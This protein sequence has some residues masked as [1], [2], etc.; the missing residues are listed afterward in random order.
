MKGE[1]CPFRRELGPFRRL[2]LKRK[3]EYVPIERYRT[4]HVAYEYDRLAYSHSDTSE[5]L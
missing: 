2:E 5:L 1:C 3:A 4:V